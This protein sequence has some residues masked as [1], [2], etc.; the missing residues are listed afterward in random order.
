MV[1]SLCTSTVGAVYLYKILLINLKGLSK[2]G[3]EIYIFDS[4]QKYSVDTIFMKKK[5]ETS[6]G[7]ILLKFS[8]SYDSCSLQIFGS[9]LIFEPSLI[10]YLERP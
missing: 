7:I 6:K 9:C 5:H 1:L 4:F 3:P 8:C 10:N 2:C